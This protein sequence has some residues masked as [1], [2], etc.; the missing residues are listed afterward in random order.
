MA[1]MLSLAAGIAAASAIPIRE[2]DG[3]QVFLSLPVPPEAMNEYLNPQLQ[4]T[5][6]RGSAWLVVNFFTIVKLEVDKLIPVPGLSD[7]HP[8]F[9]QKTI[10]LVHEANS[11]EPAYVILD[12]DFAPGFIDIFETLG[13]GVTQ[14]GVHCRYAKH[15]HWDNQS[16]A[17][18]AHDG[19]S[20]SASYSE[21]GVADPALVNFVIGTQTR[22]MQDGKKGKVTQV[23]QADR[24]YD[25]K[26]AKALK[27]GPVST[28]V[29]EKRLPWAAGSAG[30]WCG[31]DGAACFTIPH[32]Q[33]VDGA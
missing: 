2:T 12:M 6:F 25:L 32:M 15:L 16:V 26:E 5:I 1:R 19:V 27:M 28:N 18:D 23:K 3:S 9:S 4:P 13:C 29:L 11:T 30:K 20:V 8:A 17:M 22:Y 7:K 10:L 21:T 31:T 33:F 24:K 14:K